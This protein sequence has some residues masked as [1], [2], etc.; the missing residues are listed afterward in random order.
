MV[1]LI[2]D[3]K[4]NLIN[5][6]IPAGKAAALHFLCSGCVAMLAAVLVFGVWYPVPYDQLSGG[7]ELFLLVMVV[8]VVCGPL[9]T[10]ILFNP[11]KPRAELYCDL[12]LVAVVQMLALIYG[13]ATVLIARPLFLVQ[14]IDRFKVVAAPD[15][16]SAA[17]DALPEGLRPVWWS[18]PLI[19]S[20]RE[21]R[22]ARERQSVMIESAVGGRDYAERPEFYLPYDKSAAQKSLLRAKPLETFLQKRPEQQGE[23]R[24]LASHKGANI[25]QW[26][27][28]PVVAREDWIAVLDNQ[29]QIQGFLKGDGF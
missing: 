16:D 26:M 18:G 29:G 24:K 4:I 8:D 27:Y 1:L 6:F 11:I 21:P 13:L 12:G 25:A 2:V 10:L 23:A 15:V 9:L 28:L 19:V 14:E 5:R 17:V 20:I 7:R 22:D 3:L